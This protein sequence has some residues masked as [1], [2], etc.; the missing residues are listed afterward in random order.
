MNSSAWSSPN[1]SPQKHT[2]PL[3][4]SRKTGADLGLR[5]LGFGAPSMASPS[6]ETAETCSGSFL[7]TAA[8]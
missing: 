2:I 7:L 4:T 5:G 6:G 1:R 8:S 3:V